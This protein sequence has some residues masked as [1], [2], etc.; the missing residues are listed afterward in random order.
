MQARSHHLAK[1]M[2]TPEISA[3][4]QKLD[5]VVTKLKATHDP[6]QKRALLKQMR[7]LMAELDKVVFDSSRFPER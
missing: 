4:E 3:I 6:E 7:T 5:E 2:T 1:P